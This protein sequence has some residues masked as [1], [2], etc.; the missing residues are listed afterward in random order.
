M[1][2][3]L[4]AIATEWVTLKGF[5]EP[6]QFYRLLPGTATRKDRLG[7]PLLPGHR[8]EAYTV[9]ALLFALLGAPCAAVAFLGNSAVALGLASLFGATSAGAFFDDWRVRYPLA[10]VAILGTLVIFYAS[11]RGRVRAALAHG[12][13]IILTAGERFR[14]F[15]VSWR[16]DINLRGHRFGVVRSSPHHAPPWP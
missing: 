10:A 2:S 8:H 16:G 9:G 3:T 11:W 4:P 12:R 7:N 1:A 13:P 5:P 15:L 6:V 14:K